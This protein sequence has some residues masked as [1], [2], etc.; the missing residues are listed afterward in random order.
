MFCYSVI[1]IEPPY[2]TYCPAD[3]HKTYSE[4]REFGMRIFWRPA[5]F[6]DNSGIDPIVLSSRRMGSYFQKGI[7]EV[8]RHTVAYLLPIQAKLL[9]F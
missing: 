9:R 3:I 5:A 4:D 2:Y 6:E 8:S 1:D 7:N